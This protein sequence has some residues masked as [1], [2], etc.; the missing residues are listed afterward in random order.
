MTYRNDPQPADILVN[1]TLLIEDSVRIH[2][3]LCPALFLAGKLMAQDST[4]AATVRPPVTERPFRNPT[5]AAVLGTVVP[6][7]GHIYSTEYLRGASMYV[8]ALGGIGFGAITYMVDK[9]TFTFLNPTPCNP[10]PQWPHRTLGLLMVGAGVATWA[11]SAIDAP[12][13]AR[14]ANASHRRHAEIRPVLGPRSSGG[15]DLGMAMSW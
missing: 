11:Y 12:R 6:G 15:V 2:F 7:A 1:T 3:L 13:A 5:T 14:R 9:C 4:V 10:G 8:G